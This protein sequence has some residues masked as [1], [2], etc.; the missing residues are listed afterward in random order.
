MLTPFCLRMRPT[1]LAL[2]ATLALASARPAIA[3]YPPVPGHEAH[4][5][6]RG[7]PAP[8]RQRASGSLLLC[9]TAVRSSSAYSPPLALATFDSAWA[10]IHAAHFDTTFNG[11]NW[12]A[13]RD[14]LRPRAEAARDLDALRA[15]IREMLARLGQSHFSLIPREVAAP[16]AAAPSASAGGDVGISVRVMDGRAVVYSVAPE[17]PAARAGLTAGWIL[18]AVDACPVRELLGAV[19]EDALAFRTGRLR[20]RAL[21]ERQLDGGVGDTVRVRVIDADGSARELPLRREPPRGV[22]VRFGNLPPMVADVSAHAVEAAPGVDAAIIRFDAW[23]PTLAAR[24]DAAVEQHRQADGI[25]LDLRGNPGGVG[26]MVSGIAGH[27]VNEPYLLGLLR[28]RGSQ[29]RFLAN[30]RRV[31][32]R[33]TRVE[34]LSAPLA[35]LVDEATGSTSEMFAGALQQIG[36]ARIFGDTTA[37]Q[38][39]PAIAQRL[40]NGD[41]LY[42]AVADFELADGTRLEGRGVHP[43]ETAPATRADLLA[44]RDPA[45]DAA[46]RWIAAQRRDRQ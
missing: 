25:V 37:G 21:I 2:T 14:E 30:P 19:G 26:A 20:A 43:D 33:G 28:M 4:S 10:I 3:Q 6:V 46:L 8:A 17:S 12:S 40:P 36:R 32:A 42:H 5:L 34:P 31:D 22:V 27:F 16:D 39:L 23:L 38:V 1:S 45:L 41:V 13:L 9:A 24:I 11:V 18:D 15:A 35:I 29:M 44:G 7:W